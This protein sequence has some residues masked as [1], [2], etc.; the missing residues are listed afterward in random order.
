LVTLP[1]GI[2]GY[3]LLF[4]VYRDTGCSL[5]NTGILA[6]LLGIQGYW[7]LF[8]KYRNTGCSS[9]NRDTG[10]SSWYTGILAA[11]PGTHRFEY[12]SI[13]SPSPFNILK[14]N[15]LLMSKKIRLGPFNF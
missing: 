15:N 9:R 8:Q 10:G 6:A 7:L 2:Q 13:S 12:Y 5:R 1:G 4:F 11:L 14:S 3:W